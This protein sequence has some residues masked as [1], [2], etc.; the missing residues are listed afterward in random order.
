[1]NVKDIAG[2]GWKYGLQITL[3][4]LTKRHIEFRCRQKKSFVNN[5]RMRNKLSLTFT[6]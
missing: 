4:C 2:V 5:R 3:L 1:M 6:K